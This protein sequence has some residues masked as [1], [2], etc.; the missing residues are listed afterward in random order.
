ML[1]STAL[2]VILTALI[3][4]TACGGDSLPIKVSNTGVNT[5]ENLAAESE[6]NSPAN[7]DNGQ[8]EQDITETNQ[9]DVSNF[10]SG[11]Y[12]DL[13]SYQDQLTEDDASVLTSLENNLVSLA[14]HNNTVYQSGFVTGRLAHAMSYYYGEQF[15]YRFTDIES[16]EPNPNNGHYHVTVIGQRLDTT[17]ETIEDVKMMYAL[18]QNDQQEWMIYTID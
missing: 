17:T 3:V 16:I 6:S 10:K 7:D 8:Q 14:E 4:L 5:S 1:K 11:L 15:Q 9:P 13:K 12:I 18:G 2:A